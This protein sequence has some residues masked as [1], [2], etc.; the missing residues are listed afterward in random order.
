MLGLGVF[1]YSRSCHRMKPC[2]PVSFRTALLQASW[3]L[4][5]VR[6]FGNLRRF[7]TKPI[8][9][10]L[11]AQGYTCCWL[12]LICVAQSKTQQNA[13]H[14]TGLGT[15][16][17][18]FFYLSIGILKTV[19]HFE[20]LW[21]SPQS[22]KHDWA[23]FQLWPQPW[24]ELSRVQS[25]S[26]STHCGFILK[27]LFPLKTMTSAMIPV[28]R[29]LHWGQKGQRFWI[30]RTR[31]TEERVLF[32]SFQVLFIFVYLPYF[33]KNESWFHWRA[34]FRRV[35]TCSKSRSFHNLSTV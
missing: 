12:K 28:S 22:N 34:Y 6:L 23:K 24:T 26:S 11:W 7:R 30:K 33:Y 2:E 18:Y 32:N 9:G 16:S 13:A 29:K 5:W 17:G 25:H 1:F 15:Y 31:G 3:R 21:I 19:G 4:V 14:L 27:L 20:G 8:Q 10:S 35:Q